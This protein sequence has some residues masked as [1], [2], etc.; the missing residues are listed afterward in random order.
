MGAERASHSTPSRI[1]SI[2]LGVLVFYIVGVF[3]R[4]S[5][6]VRFEITN[7][8]VVAVHDV[9]LG[10]VGWKYRQELPVHEIAPGQ[11]KRLFFRPSMK[12]SYFLNFTDAQGVRHT[13]QGETYIPADDSADVEMTILSSGRVEMS[14]PRHHL[15]SWESWFGFL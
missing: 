3:I 4:H 1:L 7:R 11:S 8:S 5:Y 15:I 13:E 12:S 6:G 9:S 14:L 10:F 2:L